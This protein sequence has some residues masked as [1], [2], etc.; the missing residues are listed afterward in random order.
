MKTTRR[1][2]LTVLFIASAFVSV[3]ASSFGGTLATSSAATFGKTGIG[4]TKDSLLANRKRANRYA[5]SGAGEVTKL[6]IYLEPTTTTGEQKLKGVIYGDESGPK[7]LLG[8][9]KAL[10][11]LHTGTAGW[12]DLTFT[13]AI[14][15]SAGNYWIGVLSGTTSNVSGIRWDSVTNSRDKNTNEYTSGASNPFGTAEVDSEQMSLYATYTPTVSPPENT[16]PPTITGTAQQGQ[17]LTEHHGTWT[18]EPTSY[19]YQWQQCT[20]KGAS[21]TSI[22]GATSQTYVPAA[23]DVG[24]TIKVQETAKNEGGSGGPATSIATTVVTE[25]ASLGAA[26]YRPDLGPSW[27]EF[28]NPSGNATEKALWEEWKPWSEEHFAQLLIYGRA[29]WLETKIAVVN[30]HDVYTE[31]AFENNKKEGKVEV[32]GEHALTKTI[33]EAYAKKVKENVESGYS[34][35][36]MDDINFAGGD[37]PK[38]EV[39]TEEAYREELAKLIEEVRTSVGASGLIE[40]NSHLGDIAPLVSGNETVKKALAKVDSVDVEFGVGYNS[41]V[42]AAEPITYKEYL[43]YVGALHEKGVQ[44]TLSGAGESTEA[45][46]REEFEYALATYYLANKQATNLEGRPALHGD[47][48][49]FA[50]QS[51]KKAEKASEFTPSAP[52][53]NKWWQGIGTKLGE[54]TSEYSLKEGL[55]TRSFEKGV[56]YVQPPTLTESEA[57]H[58]VTIGKNKAGGA[59]KNA[60]GETE[61][62][63]VTLKTRKP[64]GHTVGEGVVLHE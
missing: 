57:S 59:W 2:L 61:G 54:P 48:L 46:N 63:T 24:H 41:A 30:Y 5:L 9:S 8:E 20:N 31:E 45:V 11:F 38:K 62:E 28:S 3:S 36:F 55:Y 40:I 53:V 17:T 4:G 25:A 18:N 43:E 49:N 32:E 13:T 6:S 39:Q 42:N 37:K 12:Y 50:Y 14:K 44:I 21:C 22:V 56:V 58:T 23:A 35:A 52:G 10:T 15:L 51:P 7:A 34:G 26:K 64:G 1:R 33:R 60:N 29:S 16:A 47:F 19:T 27:D